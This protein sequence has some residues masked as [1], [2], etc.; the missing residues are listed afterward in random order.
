MDDV[1]EHQ[2]ELAHDERFYVLTKNK[3]QEVFSFL[4]YNY[5]ETYDSA[6]AVA[7]GVSGENVDVIIAASAATANI[8]NSKSKKCTA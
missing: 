1:T 2:L 7:D 5:F 4:T 6:K 8:G 3:N